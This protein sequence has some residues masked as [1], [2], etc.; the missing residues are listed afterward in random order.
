LA[1]GTGGIEHTIEFEE[2]RVERGSYWLVVWV[3]L[4]GRNDISH[5]KKKKCRE[6]ATTYV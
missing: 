6:Q 5:K 2:L 3:M 1:R 4:L